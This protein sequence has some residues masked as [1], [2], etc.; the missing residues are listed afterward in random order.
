M[1]LFIGLANYLVEDEILKTAVSKYGLTQWARISSLLVRK[2]PKQCK[3]RW[4][5]WLDPSI[6]KIEWSRDEDEKLLHMAKL[7]PTQWRTIAPVVG[8]T[9]TQCLERYQK[10]LDDA[11]LTEL[12]L[13]GPGGETATPTGDDVRRMRPGELDPNP[14]SR[15]AKPDA[16][17]MDE[18]EKEMLSE[19]R[20]RLANTQGKKAKRKAREKQVDDS[21]RMAMLAKRREL[22]LAGINLKVLNKKKKQMD[23]DTDIPFEKQPALGFYDTSEEQIS[24][25]GERASRDLRELQ[26]AKRQNEER[27]EQTQKKKKQEK[28]PNAAAAFAAA[29][30]ASQIREAEQMSKRRKLELPSPQVSDGELESIVKIGQSGEA[31]RDLLEYA[32]VDA[33]QGLL[34]SYSSVTTGTPM[35][36]PRAPTSENPLMTQARNLRMMTDTQSSLYGEENTPLR[37]DGTGYESATPRHHTILTPNPLATPVTTN[38]NFASSETPRDSL[39]INTPYTNYSEKQP[40]VDPR[41]ERALL[42]SKLAALPK[43]K[44]DFQLVFPEDDDENVPDERASVLGGTEDAAERDQRLQMAQIAEEKR[45][46]QRLTRVRQLGL[47]IPKV[48]GVAESDFDGVDEI[49]RLVLAESARLIALDASRA[50]D[51]ELPKD[52]FL[53][54]AKMA[55][56]QSVDGNEALHPSLVDSDFADEFTASST[57]L[58]DSVRSESARVNKLEKK[59]NLTLGGYRS[60]ARTLVQKINEATNA[61]AQS[62]VE[63]QTFRHLAIHETDAIPRR[64]ASL[65][66]ELEGLRRRERIAQEEFRMLSSQ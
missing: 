63:L 28:R 3:A 33:T 10:L 53:Q 62:E 34:E 35:R 22:K 54:A 1:S 19:A 7:M 26:Q 11:E 4:Q 25:E 45:Q 24:N 61:L 2:T 41:S 57:G 50:N 12:G 23:Y 14:E 20:A 58:H 48:I 46:F 37:T 44:N 5:E 49:S 39:A 52:E 16:I 30:S 6:K 8:R 38:G 47:P 15:G 43:P 51:I 66:E 18:D 13:I 42:R 32:G 9:A 21:R 60:R 40:I 17:D 29:T 36:T 55:M 27:D 65:T 31:S 56:S 59:L 64:T